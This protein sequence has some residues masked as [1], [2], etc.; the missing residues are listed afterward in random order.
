MLRALWKEARQAGQSRMCSRDR[1]RL[2]RVKILTVE[3][4]HDSVQ[5]NFLPS[6]PSPTLLRLTHTLEATTWSNPF[7]DRR[8]ELCRGKDHLRGSWQLPREHQ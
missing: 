1:R 4:V 6:R 7:S 5:S 3:G 2:A 8:L